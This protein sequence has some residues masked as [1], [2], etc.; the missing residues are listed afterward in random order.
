MIKA[1][2]TS[3]HSLFPLALLRLAGCRVVATQAVRAAWI[4]LLVGC[5]CKTWDKLSSTVKNAGTLIQE[6]VFALETFSALGCRA[7]APLTLGLVAVSTNELV[8]LDV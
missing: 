3:G 4:A 7:F 8:C 5:A 6:Q 1:R 2:D